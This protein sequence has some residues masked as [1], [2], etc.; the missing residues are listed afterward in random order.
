M[1]CLNVY[2]LVSH[3]DDLR[4]C[5]VVHKDREN[6]GRHGG[7]VYFVVEELQIHQEEIKDDKEIMLI[8]GFQNGQCHSISD[9][10]SVFS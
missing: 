4:S 8:W 6:N 10:L 3:I 2:S 9:C 5:D 1:A 7:S